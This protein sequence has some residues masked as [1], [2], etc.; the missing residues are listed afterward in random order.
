MPINTNLNIAPYFD[1]F[2]LEKQFYKILFKPAYA[3]QARELTQL[4]TILQ[5]QVEQFGDN[6]YREGSIVKGCNF[7]ILDDLQFVKLT[8]KTGFDP[9]SFIGGLADEIVAGVSVPVDT[10]YEI[11]GDN[12]GLKA[13]IITA[14]RGFET[15]PPDLNTFYINYLN[16]TAGNSQFISG[17][18]LT[19]NKYRYNGS[20]LI[21]TTLNVG[22]I[23]VTNLTPFVGSSYGIQAADGVVFQKGHFLF[24]GAQTLIVSKYSNSPDDLSAGYSIVESLVSSL[25]DT[26][27]FDNA[28]GSNNENAP[29]ADRL[30]MVPTL[31]VKTTSIAD[32]DPGFFTL[33]R[34]QNGYPVT[35]RDVTQFN[36]IGEEMAK[37]TYEES[38]DYIVRDFKCSAE[39]RG[40]DLKVLVG[41]GAAYV[42]GYRIENRGD[43]DITVDPITTTEIQNNQA[44]SL[45][46]GSYVDILTIQGT[47]G[48]GYTAVTLQR[49]TGQTIG[50]AYVS[51]ITPTR[52]YLF[53]V[54]ISNAAYT[55]ANV[56]RIVG[57][58]GIIT[59]A[60]GSKLKETNRSSLVFNTGTKSLKQLTD[61]SVPVRSHDTSVSVVEDSGDDIITIGPI[62]GYDFAVDNSDMV[63]VDA[64]NTLI[65]ILSY[66]TS[67]NDSILTVY[68]DPA[69][70]SDPAGELYFNKRELD[71]TPYNKQSVEPWI[72]F[73]W[74]NGV[75]QYNLGFPDVYDIIKIEDAA[76]VDFT[77]SFRL[78]T[79]QKDSFY[80]HSYLEVIP[81]RPIPTAGVISV[82]LKVF[83]PSTST[84]KYF[85]AINSYPIDDVS[86]SLPSGYIRSSDIP[87]YTSDT[88][89]VYRLREC[90]DFRPY[91]DLDGGA[92]YTALT[93]SGSSVVSNA[94]GAQQ[95]VFSAYTYQTPALNASI[96]SDIEH[97]LSRIDMVTIDSFGKVASIKGTEAAYPVP[98]KIGTDQLTITQVTIPG[99]PALSP[100][101]AA[102]QNKDY[103]SIK[104][105]ASGVKTYT[106]KDI[107][108]FDK[109][110]KNLEYYVSLNQLEQSTQNMVVVDENG[111][112]RFKNGFLVDPFNDTNISNLRDAAFNAAIQK[113][114]SILSP[115]LTTFP[116]D[117]RYK[118]ATGAT[119]F[120][121]TS[122][123]EV[124]TLSRNDH[125][126]IVGQP[127]GTNFRNLV[128]NYW[129]YSGTGQLS[130]SHDMAHDTTS[131]PVTLDID[132]VTPFTDFVENLQTFIPLTQTTSSLVS[133]SLTSLG[134]RMFQRNSTFTDT[135]TSLSIDPNALPIENVVGDFVSDFQ[136]SPFMRARD[137]KI[138][139]SGLR[140]DTPH[141]FYFDGVAITDKVRAGDPDATTARDVLPFGALSSTSVSTDSNGVLRAV[142]ELPNNTFYVGDRTLTIADS[143]TF[144]DIESASTSRAKLEYHA[145]NIS[146][147]KSSLTTSTR[148]PEF[149]STPVVTTRNVAGRPFRHDP[150]AQTFFV[151]TGMG[152][153]ANSIFASKVDLYF[154]RKSDINGVTVMLREV[155]NGYPASAILP[156]SKVHLL[157]S[158][159][160]VSDDAS[161]VT[162][163]DFEAPVRLDVEKEYAI[164]LM[165]DANDPNYL[166]FTS[167]VGGVDLTPGATQGQAVVQDWG[168]GV[169]FSSTNNMAW[170]SYQD[171]DLKFTIYRHKFNAATG[172]VTFTNKDHEFLTLSDWTGRFTDGE[173]IYTELAL[174]GSTGSAVTMVS[175]TN[176]ITGTSLGDTYAAGDKILITAGGVDAIFE[177]AS[178][179]SSTTMTSTKKVP[180]TVG[181]GSTGKSIVTGT[182]SHYNP[183]QRSVMHLIDSSAT[184]SKKFLVAQTVKGL[185]SGITGTIGSVDNINLSY[186][187]PLIM[188]TN[189]SVTTTNLSSALVA[190]DSTTSYTMPMQFGNKNTFNKKGVTVFSKS[191]DIADAKPFEITVNMSNGSSETTTP[192]VDLETATLLSYQYK[193]TNVAD[194]TSKYISKTIELAESLDAEDMEVTVT[195]YRP[196]GSNIKVYIKPQNVY[197]SASFASIPWMELEAFEGGNSYSSDLNLSD[198]REIKYKVKAANLNAGTLEYTSTGGT[199]LGY[200][201]FAIRIDMLSPDIAKVPTLRDMRALA[202]T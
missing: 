7:T 149:D 99:Y 142:F 106:M 150:L 80:D 26:S 167:K 144:A 77:D 69:A 65:P 27:L 81:G 86:V 185:R 143:S 84:G 137:I 173:E 169:L 181:A 179:D 111:L 5:N 126:K 151:K 139:V 171:E 40:T 202:L 190:N 192:V 60:A 108:G 157:A 125:T 148:I 158:A 121:S 122:D 112:T 159:V 54:S 138:F 163:I 12:S 198:Y 83:K 178:V 194:T 67:V 23:N 46:Y 174:S 63:F 166:A 165:P 154:K 10:Q 59:I 21:E 94:V 110:I 24:A 71:I 41:K 180:Y 103:Y 164:V 50:Q 66:T 28:N 189:D 141:Y 146:I 34:Y 4:Q 196:S 1:D 199:F 78:V 75:T 133:S 22:S 116:L 186:I 76:N 82:N 43:Q 35:I 48:L 140:P 68:L 175:G 33:I 88:G 97:Y 58:A 96:T 123:A 30:K 131:N 74:N 70:N 45:E 160:N 170:K 73:V 113:D 200:R 162:T 19:I 95:P 153:G 39:R 201:K 14:S 184:N 114:D 9:E 56:E 115:S 11:V 124:A 64:S 32:I 195:A 2:N 47:V 156:F 90:I 20:V 17:E 25:Q 6:I 161:A 183:L 182:I 187:Q 177:I 105:K 134:S 119:V 87:V 109:R 155:V 127:Y 52:L 130:P 44:T 117:L 135:N 15:R 100:K 53:G 197:D 42:K 132:L 91:R 51:N 129:S 85:F 172:S 193:I 152:R 37:R 29:G 118:S 79:N 36:S 3:V 92:S 93:E 13:S 168:D 104:T 136:F 16:T 107:S 102:E 18:N 120:P 176:I 128:S 55:F 188:K 101:E 61:I 147:E 72:K 89:S 98:P 57:T 38:G 62:V 191:N 31:T 49:S 145:Y 8:D